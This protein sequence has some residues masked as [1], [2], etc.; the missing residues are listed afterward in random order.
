MGFQV[1]VKQTPPEVAIA[2]PVLSERLGG[3]VFGSDQGMVG[4]FNEVIAR[5]TADE[6]EKRQIKSGRSNKKTSTSWLSVH[7]SQRGWKKPATLLK[8]I[9]PSQ[10]LSWPLRL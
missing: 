7:A 3:I 2:S 5:H 10:A 8:T 1:I 6:L 4:Q 9:S